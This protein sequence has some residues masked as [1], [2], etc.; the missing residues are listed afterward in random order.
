MSLWEK[1]A[2]TT[3]KHGLLV[4]PHPGAQAQV[5]VKRHITSGGALSEAI[6]GRVML[7]AVKLPGGSSEGPRLVLATPGKAQH[8]PGDARTHCAYITGGSRR[9]QVRS[10]NATAGTSVV[11][12]LNRGIH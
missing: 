2:C 1:F 12:R 10:R 9:S 6:V 5:I 7:K 3:N 8:R 4:L 11:A